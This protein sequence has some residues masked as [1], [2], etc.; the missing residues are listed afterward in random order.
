MTDAAMEG[1][2]RMKAPM[3]T[4]IPLPRPQSNVTSATVPHPRI[5]GSY[6]TGL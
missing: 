3:V 5:S 1:E 4:G 6:P 2:N